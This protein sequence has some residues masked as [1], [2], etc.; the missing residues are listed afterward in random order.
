[1]T[2]SVERL[3]PRVGR[4]FRLKMEIAGTDFKVG[5]I[6]LLVDV[7]PLVPELVEA[8]ETEDDGT[9]QAKL[10]DHY[11]DAIWCQMLCGEKEH[12]HASASETYFLDYFEQVEGV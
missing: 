10:W 3:T 6:F 7:K 4:L 12:L 11:P 8:T 9:Y 1:M 2:S 5:D